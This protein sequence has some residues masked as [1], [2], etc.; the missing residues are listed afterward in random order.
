MKA[1]NQQQDHLTDDEVARLNADFYSSFPYSEMNYQLHSNVLMLNPRDELFHLVSTN[2][3]CGD[4]HI[5]TG[6][7][8]ADKFRSSAALGL[9]VLSQHVAETLLRVL[10]VHAC[11]EQCPWVAL[12]ALRRRDAV[13]EIAQQ[14][15]LGT[16]LTPG[17]R[18]GL[19]KVVSAHVYGNGDGKPLA[20][21]YDE[22]LD[23]A[24]EWVRLAAELADG[25]HLYNAYKHGLT[26]SYHPPLP[27]TVT[28]GEDTFEDSMDPSF[29]YLRRPSAGDDRTCAWI[30]DF[31]PVDVDQRAIASLVLLQ[32]V[33]NV[34]FLGAI[35]RGVPCAV[36][37]TKW[38]PASFT[39]DFVA[40]KKI[41]PFTMELAPREYGARHDR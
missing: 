28:A 19:R 7:A 6:D 12:A 20:D 11:E 9:V 25:S 10:W 38:Y 8:T 26:L 23:T 14:V 40:R 24:C 29:A 34:L 16:L 18:L 13:H 30:Q 39:P 32:F 4:L 15:R 31:D 27:L 17:G 2:T 36:P 21:S 41:S 22:V 1:G 35:K 33:G 37:S 5:R 3:A